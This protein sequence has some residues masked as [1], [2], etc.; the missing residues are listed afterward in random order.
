MIG[1]HGGLV[2]RDMRLEGKDIRAGSTLSPAQARKIPEPN[3]KALESILQVKW[4]EPPREMKRGITNNGTQ[5]GA[6]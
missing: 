2:L 5:L 3:R 6:V 1:D 4:F